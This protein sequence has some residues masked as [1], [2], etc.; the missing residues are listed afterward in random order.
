MMNKTRSL[1]ALA[2]L[3]APGV[4]LAA[5]FALNEQSIKSLGT[6]LAGRAG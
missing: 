3:A 1:L 4:S 5:G 2:I 6:A